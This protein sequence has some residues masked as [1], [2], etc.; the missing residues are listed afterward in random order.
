[1]ISFALMEV[2]K[3][4]V[5]MFPS[6]VEGSRG[7]DVAPTPAAVSSHLSIHLGN[8]DRSSLLFCSHIDI[9]EEVQK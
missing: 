1:M 8:A 7:R 9:D 6:A 3:V 4:D 5:I 2:S